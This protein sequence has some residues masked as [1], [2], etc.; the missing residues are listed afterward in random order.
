MNKNESQI[1]NSPDDTDD[2]LMAVLE[3]YLSL[4]EADEIFDMINSNVFSVEDVINKIDEFE[5]N[6]EN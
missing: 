2:K 5:S 4:H 1:R 6:S 3:H